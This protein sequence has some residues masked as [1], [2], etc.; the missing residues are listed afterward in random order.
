MIYIQQVD[1]NDGVTPIGSATPILQSVGG[2]V[3]YGTVEAPSLV[4]NP[5]HDGYVLFYSSGFYKNSTY[6]VSYATSSG[7]TGPYT[8]HGALLQTGTYG[9][10]APGGADVT[11]NGT[12]MVFHANAGDTFDGN[13]YM[14]TGRVSYEG[15]TVTVT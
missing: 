7:I 10:N 15:T 2:T 8:T 12:L 6:T 1:V 3:D 11:P 4:M 13:R 9:L 14:W 5:D